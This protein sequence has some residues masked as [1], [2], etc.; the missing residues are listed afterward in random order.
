VPYNESPK[1]KAQKPAENAAFPTQEN[2]EEFQKE[3]TNKK[4]KKKEE[5]GR[6]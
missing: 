6:T 1:E 5:R 4:K 3:K 2:R